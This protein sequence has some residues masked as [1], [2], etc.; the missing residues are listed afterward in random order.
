MLGFTTAQ[1]KQLTGL[2]TRQLNYYDRTG[3]LCPSIQKASGK[4]S[5]RQ[6]SFRDVVALKTVSALHDQGG[7]SLQS[8][9]SAVQYIQNIE[10]KT[11]S[12][13]VLAVDGNDIV[14]FEG[15]DSESMV[16][17][18]TSLVKNPGQLVYVFINVGNITREIEAAIR[19]V[20]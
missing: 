11:L 15:H 7:A 1:V 2:S 13:V 8:I 17:M 18:V 19:R 5:M 9:R 3:L 14:K 16:S 4:G 6:Y 10:G 12:E 20:G